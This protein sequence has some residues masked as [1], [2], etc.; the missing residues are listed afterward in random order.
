MYGCGQAGDAQSGS[1]WVSRMLL[2]KLFLLGLV[3]S[4]S[5]CSFFS[6]LFP[7]KQ[8][9]YRYS[10]EIPS[11][12]IPPDLTASTLEDAQ[13]GRKTVDRPVAS[14]VEERKEAK[15]SVKKRKSAKSS[16]SSAPA[17]AQ[18]ADDVPLIEI[19]EAYAETWNDV[20]RALGRLKVE[21]SDQNRSDGVYYVY[22]GGVSPNKKKE[23][24]MM[25]EL[26]S[27]FSSDEPKASEF[28]IKLEDKGDFTVIYVLDQSGKKT[29]EGLGYELL[30][31]L[32]EKLQT[33]DKPEPE[34]EKPER[35]K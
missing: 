9:Q 32:N 5:A 31:K 21:V 6:S 12:E 33:I 35:G 14:A 19:E 25:G 2:K 29:T 3:L 28:R 20:N 27:W 34:H 22:Y 26:A 4:L 11:L 16:K 7:D 8:K 24:T 30:S 15:P 17:I 18:T 1:D 23:Q 13:G 10:S